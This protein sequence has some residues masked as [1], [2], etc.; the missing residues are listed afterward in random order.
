[1]TFDVERARADTPGC[2]EI[3]HLNN[4]GA[5]LPP[6]VVLE[7]VVAHLELEARIGGYAAADAAAEPLAAVYD[8]VASLIGANPDEIAL[9]ESATRA[10]DMAFYALAATLEPGDRVLVGQS[11]Y[12][13]NVI[14]A[15]QVARRTGAVVDAVPDDERGQLSVDA[16]AAMIDERT[17]L[18]AIGWI[19]TQGGLVNPVHAVG[20][21]TRGRGV[22]FLLDATQA[23]GQLVIDVD[24]IGCDFLCAT[25]RKYLRA[26]RGTGFLYV[27][28]D[29]IERLEPPFL[30]VHAAR[31][32]AADRI[33][34][35][36][37]ARRFESWE[38]SYANRLGLGA[39]VDY[40]RG[41]S[42][43]AI[44]ARVLGLGE[45][46][47]DRLRAVPGVTLHDLGVQRCALVSFTVAGV[48]P[49]ALA[50]Q[51]RTAGINISVSTIDFARLDFEARG[52]QAVARASPHYY[53]TEAELDRLA[54]AVS[55]AAMRASP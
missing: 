50:A 18:V 41:W 40:A 55:D 49:F 30:D 17:K 22:P 19:P 3:V 4:A 32:V 13:S 36:P 25:G 1:V 20:A 23:A 5:S 47:R 46:L 37:D 8:S 42:G 28:R 31:W 16:L 14:A 48:D 43:P 52:L 11:E 45:A 2:R 38:A 6:Q 29:W 10:W 9:V 39:A 26:P 15:L 35:R 33:E 53:N 24:T 7:T 21:V 27:R 34:I 44:E 54:E 12:A 51:L